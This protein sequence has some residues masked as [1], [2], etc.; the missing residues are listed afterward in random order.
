MKKLQYG[1]LAFIVLLSVSAWADSLELKNGSLI[2]GTYVGGTE[3]HVSFRVGSTVQQYDVADIVS[4][5]FESSENSR[6]GGEPGFGTRD[7][8][9]SRR[10]RDSQRADSQ[11]ADSQRERDEEPSPTPR[12]QPYSNSSSVTIPMGTRLTVR[13]IDAIDS[14]KNR[15][16]ISFLPLWSSPYM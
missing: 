3:T 5:K 8:P 16:G 12:R 13:T 2:K 6:S 14:D 4:I 10:N 7:N 9:D 11:R 1:F 15:V